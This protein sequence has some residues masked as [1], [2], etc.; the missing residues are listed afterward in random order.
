MSAVPSQ[1]ESRPTTAHQ[2]QLN[3]TEGA[4]KT[5]A[6]PQPQ[7]RALVLGNANTKSKGYL[8]F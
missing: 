7:V 5:G 8:E 3:Q 2:E 4:N 6:D 1:A